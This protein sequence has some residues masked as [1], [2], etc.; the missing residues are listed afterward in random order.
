MGHGSS[1]L[2]GGK[3]WLWQMQLG[4]YSESRGFNADACVD[5]F[6]AA[7]YAP[8]SI[9]IVEHALRGTL[10]P[11][12]T[13]PLSLLPGPQF[14]IVQ[15]TDKAGLPVERPSPSARKPGT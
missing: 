14:D 7:G 13:E 8:L 3:I 1:L 15:G 6:S 12:A 5:I 2:H 4:V 11:L 10:A 9:R